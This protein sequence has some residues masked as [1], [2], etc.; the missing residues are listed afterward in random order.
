MYMHMYIYIIYKEV[1][2]CL[3]QGCLYPVLTVVFLFLRTKEQGM[4]L[5]YLLGDKVGLLSI[6]VPSYSHFTIPIPARP[7]EYS[8]TEVPDIS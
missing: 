4:D 3:F 6:P 1:T 5:E 7:R 8:G 2:Q